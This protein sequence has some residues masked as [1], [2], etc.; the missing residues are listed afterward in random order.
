MYIK[1]IIINGF[2]SFADKTVFDLDPTLSISKINHP[3]YT[4]IYSIKLIKFICNYILIDI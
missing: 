2:K 3:F 4:K 1:E